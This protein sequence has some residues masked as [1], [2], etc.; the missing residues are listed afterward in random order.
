MV[1]QSRLANFVCC[2]RLR[3]FR[4]PTRLVP[5]K[6]QSVNLFPSYFFCVWLLGSALFFRRGEF[7]SKPSRRQQGSV[8]YF[9][10]AT[11]SGA[12]HCFHALLSARSSLEGRASAI[13]ESPCTF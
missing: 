3:P 12:L 8:S 7:Y 4:E 2:C 11:R 1:P 13:C 10:R 6:K 5:Q 9:P